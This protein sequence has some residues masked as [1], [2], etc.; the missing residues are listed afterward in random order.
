MILN[1]GII[2]HF[3][4]RQLSKAKKKRS[5]RLIDPKYIAGS[6]VSTP[7]CIYHDTHLF[8]VPFGMRILKNFI[9][10]IIEK[11][12]LHLIYKYFLHSATRTY[13]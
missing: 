2:K 13:L 6:I 9:L 1:H 4:V 8:I 3:Q 10:I 12:V 7:E 5:R 11:L